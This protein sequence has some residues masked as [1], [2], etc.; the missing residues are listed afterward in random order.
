MKKLASAA[1]TLPVEPWPAMES[2]T[3][4]R[5]KVARV[6]PG[7]L[8]V[9][10]SPVCPASPPASPVAA[11]SRE[12]AGASTP[13]ML[14]H[15]RE[16]KAQ[17]P[18]T[19]L[20][21]R[22]GDFYEMF[23]ED[24]ELAARRP[25]DHPDLPRRRRAARRRAG[26]GRGR[27]PAAAR[28]RGPPR[29]HLR[30]GGGSPGWPRAWSGARWWRRVTPGRPARRRLDSGRPEQL[31]RRGWPARAATSASPRST[32][33]PA[34]SCS[35][36]WR[37]TGWRRRSPGFAPAEVVTR[38]AIDG[39]RCR[40]GAS[41]DRHRAERWEFDPDARSRG[42][43]PP[44]R[45]R[46]ARRPRHRRRTT[47]PRVGAG[48]R[49][50]PL[51]R[52]SCSRPGC[53]ISPARRSA[54]ATAFLW[55]DEMTR[56]NLEL[57]EPLRAGARG[58]TCW[59]R[60]TDR[61]ADGRPAAAAVAALAAPRSGGDR[62]AARRGGGRWCATAAGRARLR[63]ALD[64]VRDLERLAGRAAAGRAT[65]RELGALR[66]SFLRL[67]DVAEALS[68]SPARTAERAAPP[69]CRG[70][71]R[72][73][74]CSADL[75]ADAARRRSSD[76]PPPALADGGVIRPG[77]DAELDE[78]RSLRDG[79]RQYI[80]SLQ[81]RERER[82]GISSLKVGFNKVFGYYLEITNAHAGQ[83]SRRLRA[84][85]DPGR[86]RALRHAG[87]QGVRV[88]GARRRGA[89]R[90]AGGGAVRRAARGGGRGASAG[91]SGPRGCW[92]ARRLG[93][94][95]RGGRR[96]AATCGPRS[97]GGFELDAARRAAIR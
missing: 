41:A 27:V 47:P 1:M 36:R 92:P 71:G 59:R 21:Y 63:E 38:R 84:A 2:S 77:Y 53:P 96:R 80:A 32:S 15:W 24:A 81:Q 7:L 86:R 9:I 18:D 16:V 33:A 42:A 69:C 34:S 5:R 14:K 17:H 97:H 68:A 65:P 72:S 82:T 75:A 87:A 25:R 78:L 73:S 19:I 40:D 58:C 31:D 93:R 74:T 3:V 56:R 10:L 46:L 67:P 13:P 28:G 64:G 85:A 8:R 30:A 54:E 52:P 50:A 43:G 83:G 22:V 29:R 91:S 48:G 44:L 4:R 88:E 61:H 60:S 51:P 55:L 26:Q 11:V 35:R 95:G 49:A 89:D 79:G 66:D 20:F 23:H 57:V 90:R 12:T 94:P 37:R 76:R 6:R 45:A 62:R 70:V 39:R